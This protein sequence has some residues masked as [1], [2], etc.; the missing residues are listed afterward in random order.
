M[1]DTKAISLEEL[2]NLNTNYLSDKSH[3]AIRHSLAKNKL[4]DVVYSLDDAINQQ[5]TFSIDLPSLPV[6]NQKQ[7]GRC[8]IFSALNLLREKIAKELNIKGQFEIS[9]NYIAFYDKLE[10]INYTLET[11]ISLLNEGANSYYRMFILQNGISDGGQWDMFVSLVKKYGICP[12]ASMVETCQSSYTIEMNRL[13]NSSIRKF[14]YE[15]NNLYKSGSTYKA[16]EILKKEYLTRFYNLLVDCF[17]IP[18]K[19]FDFEYIDKD[20]N[21]HIEKELTPVSF[22]KKY[23]GDSI[24]DYVSVINAPTDDKKYNT[25][26][27]VKYLGNVIEGRKVTH[28]NLEMSRMKQLIINQLKDGNMVWFG[29]DVS[30]YNVRENELGLWDDKHFDYQSC[31]ELDVSFDKKAMLD[32]FDSAM[33]HAMVITGVDIKNG[34]PIRWK[35]QNSWGNDTANK[36]YFVMSDTFFDKFVY[37]AAILK[38]YLSKN[39]LEAY[40]KTPI[41][42]E[43][44]DPFGTLA[45]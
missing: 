14:A 44:W 27:T 7:S 25:S 8:W 16:I 40:N 45:D 37:Q 13:I 42:L 36:G 11:I 12:K 28:L 26:Y 24:L 43:P 3:T 20:N 31:F 22:F 35:I 2:S 18:P 29:S 5:F 6:T 21:Y 1:E 10:K 38:K 32:Y 23:I 34:K 9:Q 39:E 15:V 19:Q 41:E 30:R 4:K 17:G 33:N